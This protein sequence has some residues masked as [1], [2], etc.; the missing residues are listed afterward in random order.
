MTAE[1]KQ[2]GGETGFGNAPRNAPRSSLSS[3]IHSL[4]SSQV[5]TG[6]VQA[7]GLPV[8]WPD[9]PDESSQSR[10]LMAKSS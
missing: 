8:S 7:R 2:M 5:S 10:C 3:F 6:P 4:H 1:K 9:E